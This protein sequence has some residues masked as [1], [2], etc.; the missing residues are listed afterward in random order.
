[1]NRFQNVIFGFAFILLGIAFFMGGFINSELFGR[2]AG[3]LLGIAGV[4][5]ILSTF[6]Y[7]N[8]PH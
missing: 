1:M 8:T 7:R 5:L 6:K 4:A 2:V 3:I